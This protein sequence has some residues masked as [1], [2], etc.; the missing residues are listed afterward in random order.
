M[1][2]LLLVRLAAVLLV[3]ALLFA[4]AT[5]DRAAAQE[6]WVVHSF[7][8]VYVVNADGTVAATEDLQVEFFAA[9]HGIFRYIPVEYDYRP[10][11]VRRITLSNVRVDDGAGHSIPAT[12]SRSGPNLEVRIGDPNRTVTG[13]QRYRITYTVRGGLN[14]FDDHDEFYWNVTGNDW[15]VS[16]E[17]VTATVRA[18]TGA[19]TRITCYQGSLGST[20]P[21]ISSMA[22]DAR[23]AAGSQ[24]PG[25]GLTVVV[26]LQKGVVRVEPPILSAPG[27]GKTWQESLDGFFG[28]APWE[29]AVAAALTLLAAALLA[30]GWWTGG[31]DRWFG[32]RFYA[33]PGPREEMRRLFSH[34]TVVVEYEP[35]PVN[36][37]RRLRPGEI[38][39]LLDER[40]D[41]LDVSATIVDLAVRG[42]LHIKE[43]RG[44]NVFDRGDYEL[45]RLKEKD[46]DLL[47]YEGQ[48]FKALFRQRKVVFLSDLEGHLAAD[49][50]KVKYDLYRQAVLNRFFDRDPEA[51]RGSWWLA[52]A[53]IAT[54]GGVAVVV[55]GLA[56]GLGLLA[57]PLALAGLALFALAPAMP[58]RTAT[59]RQV[60]RRALG[61]RRF[62]VT[63]ETERERFAEKINY[64]DD[65]LPYAIVF[66]CTDKWAAAFRDLGLE[67]RDTPWFTG[68]TVYAT[69]G[70]AQSIGRFSS[71]LSGT[72]VSTPGGSGLSGFSGP[73]GGSGCGENLPGFIAFV[74]VLDHRQQEMFC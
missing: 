4:F 23:F 54:T 10:G 28:T 24:P 13:R 73:S 51:V 69:L 68:A 21:C 15:P 70:F 43:I 50:R 3:P 57:A 53:V 18:P 72:L 20:A 38:G 2:R 8:A 37:G 60:Y 49:V 26:A 58:R 11:T 29:I 46:D 47:P 35:P 34:E 5:G 41:T 66:H 67:E 31:R 22:N 1:S 14:A 45:T 44:T 17:Q 74:L 52:A 71:T 65:Y 9:R 56:F 48:L 33:E 55:L 6:P 39:V 7:D 59:G 19:I 64:F 30:A 36:G 63:A 42:Y 27:Q 32:D 12:T 40:A 61:F 62:M 16:L 25:A